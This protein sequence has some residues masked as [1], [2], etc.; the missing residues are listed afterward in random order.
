MKK[1]FY[2]LMVCF[3]V[4]CAT[5][6]SDVTSSQFSPEKISVEYD[7]I[8]FQNPSVTGVEYKF[9]FAVENKNNTSVTIREAEYSFVLSDIKIPTAKREINLTIEPSKSGSFEIIVPVKF[10]EESAKL[11]EFLSKKNADYELSGVVRGEG[12]EIPIGAKYQ[13][14]LP[15]IPQVSVPGASISSGEKGEIGFTFDLVISNNNTFETKIDYFDYK[16]MI[17]DIPVGEGRIAELEKCPPNAQL[18]YTFPAKID[19]SKYSV[20]VKKMLSQKKF[21]YVVEGVLGISGKTFPV[22]RKGSINFSM[23]LK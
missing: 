7:R 17:E 21:N 20:Q 15:E 4:A 11:E 12:F 1:N 5:A 23:R 13:I 8:D 16:V 6:K 3:L 19:L 9:R 14:I 10:P 22:S 2:M 18:S